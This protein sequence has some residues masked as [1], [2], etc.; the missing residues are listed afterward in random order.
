MYTTGPDVKKKYSHCKQWN[1]L[2][3]IDIKI[4]YIYTVE[5]KLPSLTQWQQIHKYNCYH[6]L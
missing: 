6:T 3:N 1:I 4:K 5:L 2:F